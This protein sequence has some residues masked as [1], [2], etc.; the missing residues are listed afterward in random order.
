[1]RHQVLLL[2]LVSAGAASAAESPRELFEKRLV[3]I[4]KSPNPSS[5][6]QCHLSGVDIKDYIRPSH[7]DTFASLRDRGLIDLDAPERSKILALIKMGEADKGASPIHEKA[8]KAEYEAFAD[9]VKRS[10]ADPKLRA[11]P[12][13]VGK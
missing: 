2:V 11:L 8:R 12:K 7:E 13:F 4:F 9:W 3:P 6:V 10:A 5:C 1:M